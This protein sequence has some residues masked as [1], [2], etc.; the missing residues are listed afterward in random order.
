MIVAVHGRHTNTDFRM[1]IAMDTGKVSTRGG[2]MTLGTS[3]LELYKTLLTGIAHGWVL[4][5]TFRTDIETGTAVAFAWGT[6]R[7]IA[8]G[9]IATMMTNTD[10]DVSR[11]DKSDKQQTRFA[12]TGFEHHVTS[13]PASIGPEDAYKRASALAAHRVKHTQPLSVPR[14]RIAS[15][16][17]IIYAKIDSAINQL[18][19]NT[20]RDI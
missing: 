3:T 19:L 16:T 4:S 18:A 14:Q 2:K 11:F 15:H 7:R 17:G 13:Y 6:K 8:D 9:A 12:R 5:T 10:N 20:V 1:V